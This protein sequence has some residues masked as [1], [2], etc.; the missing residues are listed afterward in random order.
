MPDLS[1]REKAAAMV[2]NREAGSFSEACRILSQHSAARRRAKT[3]RKRYITTP[4]PHW[5]DK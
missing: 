2:R 3:A 1:W 5:T 4:R